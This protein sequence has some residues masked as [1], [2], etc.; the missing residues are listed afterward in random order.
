MAEVNEYKDSINNPCWVAYIHPFTFIRPDDEKIWK[1][2]L[3]EI[4]NLTYQNGNLIRIVAKFDIKNYNLPALIC[5][6]GAI[7]IPKNDNFKTKE[8]ALLYFSELFA[9]LL[10]SNF[11]LEGID[12]KDI[13]TGNLDNKWAIWPTSFGESYI[14]NMHSK[15][16]MKETTNFDTIFLLRPRYLKVS[17]FL[18][19][20]KVGND[21]FTEIK[22]LSPIFLLRGFTEFKYKNWDLVLSNLWIIIEQLIDFLWENKFI[23]NKKFNPITPIP[24]RLNSLKEDNRT[25]TMGVKQELLFQNKII[26][27][28]TYHKL[29]TTRKIRNKLVHSGKNVE[30]K[31]AEE[32]IEVTFELLKKAYPKL[33]LKKEII[34]KDNHFR[35]YNEEFKPNFDSWKNLPDQNILEAVF[36]DEITKRIKIKN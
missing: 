12:Q 26:T 35:Y 3:E 1:I 5:Y 27:E 25:W 14:S 19:K 7:A 23:N 11:Y 29:S 16:R 4:N 18:D 36:G 13:V 15:I 9:K 8:S 33:K 34:I 32:I 31:P 30:K 17:Q 2:K 20:I 10:L 6:D 21:I 22:N 24:N 28:S